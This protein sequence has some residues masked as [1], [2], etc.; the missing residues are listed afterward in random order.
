ML[1]L[2]ARGI[3][4]KEGIDEKE[5]HNNSHSPVPKVFLVVDLSAASARIRLLNRWARHSETFVFIAVSPAIAVT[6]FP[7]IQ[8]YVYN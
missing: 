5:L 4:D 8:T 6:A 7:C 3:L 2:R 1:E